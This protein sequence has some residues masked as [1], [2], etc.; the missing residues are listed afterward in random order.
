MVPN[1]SET[2]YV[3]YT[4]GYKEVGACTA[5]NLARATKF[6]CHTFSNYLPNTKCCLQ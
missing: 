6:Y 4:V 5:H 1:F 3:V 2:L